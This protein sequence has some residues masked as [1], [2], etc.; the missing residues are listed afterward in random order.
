M[1]GWLKLITSATLKKKFAPPLLRTICIFTGENSK[2]DSV[3][4]LL[5]LYMYNIGT[6]I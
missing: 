5:Y 4:L 2:R 3:H 1:G 6:R